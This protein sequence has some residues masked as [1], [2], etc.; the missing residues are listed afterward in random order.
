MLST[1]RTLLGPGQAVLAGE[2]PGAGRDVDRGRVDAPPHAFGELLRRHL[3]FVERHPA[4]ERDAQ[5]IADQ[6]G[7]DVLAPTRS[8]HE[9]DLH[10]PIYTA[11]RATASGRAV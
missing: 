2:P 6:H 10:A 11:S 9:L 1:Q 4:R 3:R 5:A 7:L 8:S